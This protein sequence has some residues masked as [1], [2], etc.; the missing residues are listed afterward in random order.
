M[1]ESILVNSNIIACLTKK[2]FIAV[3]FDNFRNFIIYLE[4]FHSAQV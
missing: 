4:K 2:Y 3:T 1:F